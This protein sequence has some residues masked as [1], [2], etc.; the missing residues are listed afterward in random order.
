M[1]ADKDYWAL[2]REELLAD[3]IDLTE[4]GF[5]DEFEDLSFGGWESVMSGVGWV[6][7][8]GSLGRYV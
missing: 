8:G 7:R 6:S 2:F 5:D 3:S 4:E 1:V